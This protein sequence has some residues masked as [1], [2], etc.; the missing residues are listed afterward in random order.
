MEM[1]SMGR[2]QAKKSAHELNKVLEVPI[3]YFPRS[4]QISLKEKTSLIL[5]S[6]SNNHPIML[7]SFDG[8]FDLGFAVY[9][10]NVS[11]LWLLL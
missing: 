7:P 8:V 1:N 6:M 3:Y 9:G 11:F 5:S 10:H 4:I 2:K